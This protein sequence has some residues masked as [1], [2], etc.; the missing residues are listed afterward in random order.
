VLVLGN[1]LGEI[2]SF[3]EDDPEEMKNAPDSQDY[4]ELIKK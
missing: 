4:F 3:E 1:D 2:E